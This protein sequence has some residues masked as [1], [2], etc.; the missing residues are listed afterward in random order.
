MLHNIKRKTDTIGFI[1]LKLNDCRTISCMSS[2][3]E[4]HDWNRV[5]E[6]LKKGSA[7]VEIRKI[8]NNL[9]CFLKSLINIERKLPFSERKK[10]S[11]VLIYFYSEDM[12]EHIDLGYGVCAHKKAVVNVY[13]IF[14]INDALKQCIGNFY[15]DNHM[16]IIRYGWHLL[17]SPT[18]TVFSSTNI[19]I[20]KIPYRD[21]IFLPN[22]L[23]ITSNKK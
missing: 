21:F 14:K 8:A 9:T 23:R 16:R 7:L 20:K 5:V 12:E 1:A 3:I 10:D 2:V 18:P 4:E 15:Y 6:R 19:D 17:H 11:L 22:N 13:S